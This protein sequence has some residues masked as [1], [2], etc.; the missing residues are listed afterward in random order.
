MMID[1][2][3]L[4]AFRIFIGILLF[5]DLQ[6]R[7]QPFDAFL[8][9]YANFHNQGMW[10]NDVALNDG[11]G[12]PLWSLVD[13]TR[14]T[15]CLYVIYTI[16]I[17]FFIIGKWAIT[18][19]LCWFCYATLLARNRSIVHGGDKVLK[20]AILCFT[21]LPRGPCLYDAGEF[22]SNC[23]ITLFRQRRQRYVVSWACFALRIQLASI[24][25]FA[26]FHKSVEDYLVSG[27]AVFMTLQ[28]ERI[29]SFH[30][31]AIFTSQLHPL[32]LM[33]LSRLTFCLELMAGLMI[34]PITSETCQRL[35]HLILIPLQIGFGLHLY[36]DKFPFIM[37][38]LHFICWPSRRRRSA[39]P[40]RLRA[41]KTSAMRE[42]ISIVLVV[43]IL[44]SN[45]DSMSDADVCAK[46]I[47]PS[48]PFT[49]ST[50]PSIV[51]PLHGLLMLEQRWDMFPFRLPQ[52]VHSRFRLVGELT[53]GSDVDLLTRKR[54]TTYT[55]EP[56]SHVEHAQIFG[57]A[58]WRKYFI[59]LPKA[60]RQNLVDMLSFV[61][62]K[63]NVL[64]YRVESGRPSLKNVTLFEFPYILKRN[65]VPLPVIANETTPT[66]HKPYV[67]ELMSL[68]CQT[69]KQIDNK[70]RLEP[71]V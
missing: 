19:L 53:D 12:F 63:Y 46:C 69:T 5:V 32:I 57:N 38:L 4:F 17:F 65:N 56:Y 1:T 24:Y 2:K 62:Y 45:L 8:G 35:G 37:I 54:M 18:P 58:V 29:T 71:R 41:I 16:L 23:I 52:P 9:M 51:R 3:H 7:F 27:E 42:I 14:W 33:T 61:C 59:W 22:N 50:I 70:L 40:S 13:D 39:G 28:Y 64:R 44:V 43:V 10:P 6:E 47:V 26:V 66:T 25:V 15:M 68:E 31:I 67:I 20:H 55:T 34:M 60:N 11:F 48:S 30:P 21:L 49:D 36:L